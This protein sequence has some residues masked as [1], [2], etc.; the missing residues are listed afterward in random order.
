MAHWHNEKERKKQTNK[1]K[2]AAV[3]VGSSVRAGVVAV[4]AP[5]PDV[6]RALVELVPVDTK[7][8]QHTRMR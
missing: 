2:V 3:T 6:R 8:H 5:D 1:E 4:L 7:S